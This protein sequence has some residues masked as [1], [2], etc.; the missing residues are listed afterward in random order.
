MMQSEFSNKTCSFYG[1]SCTGGNSFSILTQLNMV[2][3]CCFLANILSERPKVGV[4]LKSMW[5]VCASLVGLLHLLEVLATQHI[6]FP[7]FSNLENPIFFAGNI[8]LLQDGAVSCYNCAHLDRKVQIESFV[9]SKIRL[10]W[11]I[12]FIFLTTNFRGIVNSEWKLRQLLTRSE[13]VI[14][15]GFFFLVFN[16]FLPKKTSSLFLNKLTL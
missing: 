12:F 6:T 3:C 15:V 5:L 4:S 11:H 13:G 10:P 16:V 7:I 1:H 9:F 2:F 8:P 14:F